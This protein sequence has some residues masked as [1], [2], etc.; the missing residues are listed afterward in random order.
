MVINS[1]INVSHEVGLVWKGNFRSGHT[2]VTG[3]VAGA[4]GM[5]LCFECVVRDVP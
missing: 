2:N 5:L 3:S 4:L 1:Y